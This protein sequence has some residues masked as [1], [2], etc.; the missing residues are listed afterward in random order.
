LRTREQ[1]AAVDVQYP[2]TACETSL[3]SSELAAAPPHPAN[4]TTITTARRI[5]M[6]AA[7]TMRISTRLH[8]VKLCAI[9][10][11][12]NTDVFL[13]LRIAPSILKLVD[14]HIERMQ[15]KQKGTK[16]S[17]S[18]AVR[19]MLVIANEVLEAAERAEKKR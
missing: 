17:R 10:F 1:L 4:V 11:F 8:G 15:Q 14:A 12:M 13:G 5:F 6:S 16:V 3:V 18:D 2:V 19:N 7:S 9:V